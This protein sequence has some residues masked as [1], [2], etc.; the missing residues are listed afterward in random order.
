MAR[1][2]PTASGIFAASP[3]ISEAASTEANEMMAPIDRSTPPVIMTS[4]TPTAAIPTTL[5][6]RS[7]LKK[8]MG[9]MNPGE[10]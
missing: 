2:T 1:A 10:K 6:W 7:M 9:W 5:A 8:L 4:V 3:A